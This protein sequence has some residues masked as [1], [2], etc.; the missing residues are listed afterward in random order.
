MAQAEFG[1]VVIGDDGGWRL[2][3][4]VDLDVAMTLI[5]VSSEDPD[6][7]EALVSYWPRYQTS[8]VPEFLDGVAFTVVEKSTAIDALRDS[9]AWAWIDLVEKRIVTGRDFQSIRRDDAFAMAVDDNGK[10]HC[11]LSIYLAPWWELHG[12]TDVPVVEQLR[13]TPLRRPVVNRDVLYGEPLLHDIARR[14]LDI[15]RSDRWPALD[16]DGE[17]A[18]YPL[19]IQVHRDWL[20]TPREDLDGRTPRELLHGAIDWIDGLTWAQRMRFEDGAELIA[21]PDDLD[22]YDTAPM[23]RQ[24]MVIYFD[25]CRELIAAGWWWC[26]SIEGRRLLASDEDSQPQLVEVLRGEREQWLGSPFEGGSPPKFIIECSRRRVPR[27]AGV[28]IVG[29]SGVQTEQHIDGC[30]CPICD[31]M[32]AGLFEVAFASLDGYHLDI[33]DEFAFSMHE[34]RE[35]WDEQLRE[36]AEMDASIKRRQAE[37]EAAGESEA[38]ELAS[39]WSGAVSEQPL[40]G[41]R[42]GIVKLAFLLAEIVSVLE[43]HDVPREDIRRLN[44]SFATF[45]TSDAEELPEH[46][47]RLSQQLEAAADQCP[48]L[49]SRVADFQSRIDELVRS[50]PIDE[51]LQFPF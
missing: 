47:T 24:E 35:A 48:E 19:T 20:M 7:W 12:Q 45:R 14:V 23:G 5:A 44:S 33:D 38:D 25:L 49:V 31:M 41:D 11:P 39:A 9:H 15:A 32:G 8:A 22:G 29:M 50:P 34:T 26:D 16:D 2:G 40:P 36:W 17:P 21:A 3:I 42:R 13:Q 46:A 51:D 4:A 10:H 37:R 18:R 28:S 1:T 30:D 27:G 6:N 43:S